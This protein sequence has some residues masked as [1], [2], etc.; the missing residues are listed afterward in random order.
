[1]LAPATKDFSPVP[2]ITKTRIDSS[3]ST[4]SIASPISVR[5]SAVK[6]LSESGWLIVIVA[7]R[8]S[9]ENKIAL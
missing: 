3:A 6:A 8:F 7:T 2:V 5:I 1:M 4:T 9:T